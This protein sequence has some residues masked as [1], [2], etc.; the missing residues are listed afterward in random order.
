[1]FAQSRIVLVM[2]PTLPEHAHWKRTQNSL[3]C[4][5]VIL[6]SDVTKV[7]SDYYLIIVV[8]FWIIITPCIKHY[9]SLVSIS[10]LIPDTRCNG[11]IIMKPV[12]TLPLVALASFPGSGNTWV[13]YLIERATGIYTGSI[14]NDKDLFNKGL[15]RLS[16]WLS[17][18]KDQSV[19]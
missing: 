9:I 3:I 13:R 11:K 19:D 4:K 10:F 18:Q 12:G 6:A 17:S 5:H 15:F 1:M 16:T 2:V 7:T 14:Y 8:A